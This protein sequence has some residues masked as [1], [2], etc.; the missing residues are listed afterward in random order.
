MVPV[1]YLWTS[2]LMHSLSTC[3]HMHMLSTGH[4]H[5]LYTCTLLHVDMLWTTMLSTYYPHHVDNYIVVHMLSTRQH[6]ACGQPMDKLWI[7]SSPRARIGSSRAGL[8]L[9]P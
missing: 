2:R 5:M 7:T 3:P 1:C 9:L 4:I 8:P 6:S